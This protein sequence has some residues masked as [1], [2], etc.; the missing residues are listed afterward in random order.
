[1]FRNPR[2]APLQIQGL[3]IQDLHGADPQQ[4]T[5][6]YGNLHLICIIQINIDPM[7]VAQIEL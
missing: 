7:Q 2:S 6:Q 4:V 5:Q 1:M 3:G